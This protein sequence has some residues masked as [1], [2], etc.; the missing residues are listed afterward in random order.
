MIKPFLVVLGK[1]LRDATRDRRTLLRLLIP[2]VLMGPLMLMVISNLISSLEA[3]AE[4]REV[5]VVGIEN[6]PTLRNFIERQTYTIKAAPADYEE[7]LRTN[8]LHEPV[9]VIG[10][11]FEK[12]LAAADKPAV[13]IVSDSANQRAS[14]GSRTVTPS[15]KVVDSNGV[16]S[17]TVLGPAITIK[18]VSATNTAPIITLTSD[19]KPSAGPNATWQNVDVVFKRV[20]GD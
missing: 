17:T 16:S 3:Q 4:Q 13:E 5:M 15:V 12:E 9:L 2:A 1:E 11:D 10:K 7:Q 8:R 20:F 19:A 6:E 18:T 14:I